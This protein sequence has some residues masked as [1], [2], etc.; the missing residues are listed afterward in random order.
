MSDQDARRFRLAAVRLRHFQRELDVKGAD[1]TFVAFV[2]GQLLD[3]A[4]ELETHAAR[5]EG[6]S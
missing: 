1:R 6:A 2:A 5:I 3:L 4:E